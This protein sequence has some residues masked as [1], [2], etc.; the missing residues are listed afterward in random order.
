MPCYTPDNA[1]DD[2]NEDMITRD[3]EIAALE[4]ILTALIRHP[5]VKGNLDF[6]KGL[7][8]WKQAGLKPEFLDEWW[9]DRLAEEKRA[10]ARAKA[11]EA[12]KLRAA[13]EEAAH[14]AALAKLTPEEL[15]ALKHLGFR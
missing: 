3:Q 6:L 13:K 10:K 2:R 1:Y 7:V 14:A 8:D 15:K 12:A 11:R 9:K 5:L 4:A